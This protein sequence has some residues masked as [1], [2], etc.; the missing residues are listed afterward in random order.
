[1]SVSLKL[2]RGSVRNMNRKL[3]NIAKRYSRLI[4]G[5]MNE[6]AE[7]VLK[8]SRENYVPV[9]TTALKYD[10]RVR[11]VESVH[12][13]WN[14][15]QI[16]YGEGEA[17][18]YALA[19]H[20]HLSEFSPYSWRNVKNPPV[21]FHPDGRGPKYLEKPLN[22]KAGTMQRELAEKLKLKST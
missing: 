10:S 14:S 4:P 17:A 12:G 9:D 11:E 1:M 8:D 16:V 21:K 20:E 5:V 3:G 15:V 18:A 2:K 13:G 22:K 19:V 7:E 6:Q